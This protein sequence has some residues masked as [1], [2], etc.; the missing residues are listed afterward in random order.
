[1]SI[2]DENLTASSRF[3]K[4]EALDVLSEC[5]L[6]SLSVDELVEK[7]KRDLKYWADREELKQS[8]T[9]HD[10]GLD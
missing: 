3:T 2:S 6:I 8:L 7:A 4:E 10:G 9:V 5:I 1:M